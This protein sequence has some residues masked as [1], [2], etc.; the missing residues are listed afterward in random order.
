MISQKF[1]FNDKQSVAAVKWSLSKTQEPYIAKG[2]ISIV[3]VF[4][5]NRHMDRWTKNH[6]HLV[7]LGF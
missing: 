1:K 5:N 7:S 4:E 6:Q 3:V 2:D